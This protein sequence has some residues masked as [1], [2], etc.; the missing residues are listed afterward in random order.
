MASGKD[1]SGRNKGKNRTARKGRQRKVCRYTLEPS[2]SSL[3]AVRE[4]IRTAL[5]PFSNIEPHVHDIVSATHEAC[6]NAV[7]HNPDT[8]GPVD[9]V[10]EVLD[11]A[12]VV[13]VADRGK[14]FDPVILP[15][16]PPDPEAMDGR[17]F[18]IIYAL[19]DEVEAETGSGGTRIRMQ[20]H[21]SPALQG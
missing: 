5:K 7:L 19:M 9:V 15:P 1:Q 8:E 12:V 3:T 14:G 21:L 20:K 11:N 4:F 17:G 10:C 16:E 6:K 13:E 18:F 2:A